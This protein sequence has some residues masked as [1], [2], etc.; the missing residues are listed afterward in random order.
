MSTDWK[1]NESAYKQQLDRLTATSTSHADTWNEQR[2]MYEQKIR[3]LQGE[4]AGVKREEKSEGQST[5]QAAKVRPGC[6]GDA[7]RRCVVCV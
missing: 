4:V 2:A 1:S 7:D 3:E 5:Q 6:D